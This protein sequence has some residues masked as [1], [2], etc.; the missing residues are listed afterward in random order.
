MVLKKIHDFQSLYAKDHK[1]IKQLNT[2]E[3]PYNFSQVKQL[4][5]YLDGEFVLK[6]IMDFA[7]ILL[8]RFWQK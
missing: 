6:A 4:D 7:P 5:T 3:Q 1:F 8:V 2:L